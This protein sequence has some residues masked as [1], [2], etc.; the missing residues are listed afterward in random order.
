MSIINGLP[1]HVLLVHF[2]VVLAPLTALLA[3]L[4]ALWPAARRRLVWLVFVLAAVVTALTPITTEAGEWL[5]HRVTETAALETHEK[6]GDTMLYFAVGLLVAAVLLLIA[7]RRD[8]RSTEGKPLTSV[9]IA[10]LV[11]AASAA[12]IVQV[13]RIGESGARSAW[14]DAVSA[15]ENKN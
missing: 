12:T 2:I 5:E 3:I 10:V 4:C 1:G 9:L 6:L 7:H 8:T 11:I 14:A 15:P 13:M